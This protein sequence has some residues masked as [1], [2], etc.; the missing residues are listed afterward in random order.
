MERWSIRFRR[1]YL[2]RRPIELFLRHLNLGLVPQ[3]NEPKGSG[4]R[5]SGPSSCPYSPKCLV[6]LSKKS[7]SGVSSAKNAVISQR[8]EPSLLYFVGF[9]AL[10]LRLAR[11]FRQFQKGNSKKFACWI[12]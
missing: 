12:I 6:K 7:L 1:R 9:Y 5:C 10:V 3:G 8:N 2:R 11:L 4:H